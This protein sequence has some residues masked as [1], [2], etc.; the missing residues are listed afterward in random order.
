MSVSRTYRWVVIGSLAIRCRKGAPDYA[1]QFSLADL[2]EAIDARIHDDSADR[3]YAKGSRLMWCSRISDDGEFVRLLIEVGDKDVS[4]MSFVNFETRQSRDIDK[5]EDEGGHFSSH[6]LIKKEPDAYGCHLILI[7]KAPGIHISSVKDHF[8]WVCNDAAFEKEAIDE[9]GQQ[10]SFR[11]I[12]EIVGHQSKTIREALRG[13]SLQ[14]IE[15]VSREEVH[16]DGLDEE[17]LIQEIVYE[18]KWQVKRRITEDQ[19]RGL[20]GKIG[21]FA[22]GF[23]AGKGKTNVYVRI[24]AENSQIKRSEIAQDAGEILEQSFVLNE[25][26]TD[27]EMPLS[28]RYDDFREDV[29]RKMVSLVANMDK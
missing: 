12:F 23:N 21:E 2:S 18:A 24:K 6:I 7:E 13:G 27:F 4:D 17:G 25:V 3:S 22:G 8:A 19:A 9:N 14:D 10:R 29:I 11:A 16:P 28:S 20:F 1:P 26:I 15:F 5:E